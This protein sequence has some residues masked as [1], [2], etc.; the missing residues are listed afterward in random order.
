MM[1][2]LHLVTVSVAR[3]HEGKDGN[4]DPEGVKTLGQMKGLKR[5]IIE[6]W[7]RLMGPGRLEEEKEQAE[8]KIYSYIGRRDVEVVFE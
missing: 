5:V 7:S 1:D 6:D 8:E 4:M 3:H 2:Y